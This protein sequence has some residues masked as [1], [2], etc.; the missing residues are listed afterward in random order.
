MC[1][2]N[3]NKEEALQYIKKVSDLKE[4]ALLFGRAEY[5]L[6]ILFTW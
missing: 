5:V 1:L 2:T 3:G 4:R 6:A